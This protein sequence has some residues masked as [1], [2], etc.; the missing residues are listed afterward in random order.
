MPRFLSLLLLTSALLLGLAATPPP[1]KPNFLLF[2]A[3]DLSYHDLGCAGNSDVHTPNL[4]RFASQGTVFPRTYTAAPT[5]APTRMSLYTGIQ[6]VRNGGHPNHSAVYPEIRTLPQY[7][8]ELGYEVAILG[9]RHERPIEQFPFKQLR[10][11]NHDDGTGL[12]L[13]TDLAGVFIGQ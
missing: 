12:D 2:M 9:K 1:D 8:G 10:G 7:L 5:C 11:R 3:D 13:D 6:P 4:D